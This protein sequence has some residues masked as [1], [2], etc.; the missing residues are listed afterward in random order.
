MFGALDISASGLVAQRQRMAVIAANV[1]NKD[2]ILDADGNYAPFRR[3]I[4]VFAP[5]DPTTGSG[6]GVHMQEIML[7]QAPLKAKHQ[8]GHELADAEGYV[9][10]PNIDT[11]TEMV[12]ALEASRAYEANIT[13][14]EATKSMTQAAI[15]LLA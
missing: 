5:G 13:A 14:A 6:Q 10:Y 3:R 12:N 9:Y 1:A 15:R 7:D 11:P 4:P 2:A 8:P